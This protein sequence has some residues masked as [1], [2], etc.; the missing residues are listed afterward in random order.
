MQ[1]EAL[2]VPQPP[3]HIGHS[4]YKYYAFVRPEK[5]G[6]GWTRDRI[7][8]A[9]AAEGIPCFS[10]SC[11]EIYLEK[12]FAPELRSP[13]RLAA[14]QELGETSLMFL[15]H[16]TL[17]ECDMHDTCRAVAKVLYAAAPSGEL[18]QVDRAVSLAAF[19]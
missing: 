12:A 17:S 16:P 5:L 19:S 2:R 14:A 1:H 3:S 6:Q 7:L 15:V 9:V 13:A 8:S 4:Y 18:R 10:G 11:S